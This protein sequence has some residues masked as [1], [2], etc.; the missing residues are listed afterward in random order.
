MFV[1]LFYEFGKGVEGRLEEVGLGRILGRLE[2]LGVEGG[3]VWVSRGR[4]VLLVCSRGFVVAR[5]G[6]RWGKFRMG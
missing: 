2:S 4:L 6:F 3:L 1:L 5:L